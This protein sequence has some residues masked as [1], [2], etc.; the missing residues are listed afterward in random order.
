MSYNTCSFYCQGFSMWLEAGTILYSHL[1]VDY[2]KAS[3][4]P[5][6]P[7]PAPSPPPPGFWT[8]EDWFVFDGQFFAKRYYQRPWLSTR[9]PSFNT[10]TLQTFSSEPFARE[11]NCLNTSI[12]KDKT[13][14]FRWK[15]LTLL[16]QIPHSRLGNAQILHLPMHGRQSNARGLPSGGRGEGR[17]EYCALWLYDVL[18]ECHSVS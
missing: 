7:P 15:D 14:V 16:I 6:P 17:G 18:I 9:W 3:T 12:L 5:L 11:T 10:K 2:C 4:T 1:C 13:L 8:F